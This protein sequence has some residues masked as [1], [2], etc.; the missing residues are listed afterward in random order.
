MLRAYS[1]FD[2]THTPRAERIRTSKP[3][4]VLVE[5][6]GRLLAG[7]LAD[8]CPRALH[9]GGRGIDA[10]HGRMVPAACSQPTAN[11]F[12]ALARR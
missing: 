5:L 9:W 3:P 11:R 8:P 1:T 6:A 12:Y 7:E 4:I 10:P 2:R